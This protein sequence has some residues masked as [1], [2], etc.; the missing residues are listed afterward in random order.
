MALL[1]KRT[2]RIGIDVGGTFTD[3]VAVDHDSLEI[4]GY[5]KVP[6]T[7]Q[8]VQGVAL[9]I[10]HA[11]QI[12]IQRLDIQPDEILFL[13]HSTTQAT[14]ALLEGDVA[15]VGVIGIGKG[16]LGWRVRRDTG[17]GRIPLAGGGALECRAVFLGSNERFE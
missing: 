7:H 2:I 4:L 5:A 16:I 15:T 3:I 14:N 9:G 11:F 10:L 6:T 12:L 8:A 13:A 1:L 17:L